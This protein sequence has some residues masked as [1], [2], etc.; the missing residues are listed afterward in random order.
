MKL[1]A[2]QLQAIHNGQ[3][4][5]L[6]I[7][8]IMATKGDDTNEPNPADAELASQLAEVTQTNTELAASVEALT[9]QLAEAT[10][11]ATNAQASAD[12]AEANCQAM[13]GIIHGRLSA[14]CV[15][16]GKE[17]LAADCTVAALVES[18]TSVSKEF[19]EKFRAGRVSAATAK[20]AQVEEQTA[21]AAAIDRAH[22]LA[23]A[24]SIKVQR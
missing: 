10:E 23:Q 1:T 21:S 12:A 19:A 13:H 15:A 6:V 8:S 4:P 20:P 11:K 3:D 24:A 7:E 5:L 2:A 14:M 9:G 17:P 18:H 16:L 22:M